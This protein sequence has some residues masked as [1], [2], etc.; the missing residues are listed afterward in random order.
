MINILDEMLFQDELEDIHKARNAALRVLL[1]PMRDNYSLPEGSIEF[2]TN[3]GQPMNTRPDAVCLLLSDARGQ[4]IPRDFVEGFDREAWSCGANHNWAWGVCRDPDDEDYWEAWQE[5]LMYA[6]YKCG[7]HVWVLHQDGDL[8][9][10]C[11]ELMTN[12]E[13]RNFGWEI[14]EDD[15]EEDQ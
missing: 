10:V 4:Y 14:D 1:H 7:D 13:K 8:W 9:A 3:E 11:P 5:I 12:E 6:Q 2:V 15:E